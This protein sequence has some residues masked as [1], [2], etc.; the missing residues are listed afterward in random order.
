MKK[1]IRKEPMF[2]FDHAFKCKTENELKNRI[3]SLVKVLEKEKDASVNII[4]YHSPWGD[5][6]IKLK[7]KSSWS[8]KNR[9][10]YKSLLQEKRRVHKKNK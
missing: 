8:L 2:R 1:A 10:C 7:F 3:I 5:K 4:Y 6:K 9:K